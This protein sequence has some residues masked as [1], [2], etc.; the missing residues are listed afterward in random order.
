MAGKRPAASARRPASPGVGFLLSQVGGRAAGLFAEL[1]AP[2]DLTPAHAG[3]LRLLSH[4]P[5]LN[6]RQLADRL[7]AVPSRVVALVDDLEQRG[8]VARERRADD[9]RSHVLLLTTRG[10]DI[11]A[12]LRAVATAHEAQLTRG[13]TAQERRTLGELLLRVAEANGLVAGVHP[14][15]RDRAGPAGR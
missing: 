8:L 6:Q 9:R 1:L 4:E 5:E 13:L 12:E 10:R 3:V 7:Q 14:G 2:L 15:F 11:L